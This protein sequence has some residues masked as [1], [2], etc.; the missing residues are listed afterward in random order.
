M[1]MFLS[2]RGLRFAQPTL[3]LIAACGCMI[4]LANPASVMAYVSNEKSNTVSV[5]DT[6][7]LEV[8]KTIKVG[9]RPRGEGF[10]RSEPAA[11]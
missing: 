1:M 9:Q 2:T 4:A 5:I 6:D 11:G 10:G 3:Q 7:K 8:I